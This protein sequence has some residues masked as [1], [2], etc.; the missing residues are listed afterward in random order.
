MCF[1]FKKS[2]VMGIVFCLRLSD[3]CTVSLINLNKKTIMQKV[4]I[5]Y[6]SDTGNTEAVAKQIQKELGK[7]NADIFDVASTSLNSLENY[8]NIIF[9]SSTW[10]IGDMQDDFEDFLSDKIEPA[11]LRDKKIAIF[12]LGDQETYEDSFVDAIGQI[13]EVIEDKGCDIIGFVP[14][15][16]YEFDESR[17]EKKGMFVGL[18]IDEENQGDLTDDRVSDWVE[19]L[20][21]KFN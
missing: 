1:L 17:A 10:G 13:Y 7:G 9:G 21:V 16:G 3:I 4:G 8:E 6:G 11:N 20:K 14:T 12:G 2:Q 19:D 5:F 15:D 18:P